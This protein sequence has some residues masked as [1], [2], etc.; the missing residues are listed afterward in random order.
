LR[1]RGSSA[2]EDPNLRRALHFLRHRVADSETAQE[3]KAAK[4]DLRHALQGFHPPAGLTEGRPR[5][6]AYATDTLIRRH[7]EV[8]RVIS[9]V[10]RK[11]KSSGRRLEAHLA[12]NLGISR[13]D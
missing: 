8:T 7:R 10:L 11:F 5:K 4:T 3:R 13:N 1:T 9:E 6:A 2:F 12:A